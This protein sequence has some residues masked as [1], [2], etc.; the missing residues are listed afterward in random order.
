MDS[1][2]AF[3][4]SVCRHPLVV[5]ASDLTGIAFSIIRGIIWPG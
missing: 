4:G 3:S 1:N 5:V 2:R